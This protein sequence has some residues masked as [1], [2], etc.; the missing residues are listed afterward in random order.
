MKKGEYGYRTYYKRKTGILILLFLI[1]IAAQYIASR[2]SRTEGT[3]NILTVMAVLTVLPMANLAAPFLAVWKYRTP[4]RSQKDMVQGFADRGLL[5]FDL[6]ITFR[7]MILPLDYC[8]VHD[9]Q[10]LLYLS[11][12]GMDT[13]KAETLIEENLRL[14][15]LTCRIFI[16]EDFDLFLTHVKKCS[17][18]DE[19]GQ[20]A[21][22]VGSILKSLSV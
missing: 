12:K 8:L 10:A 6:I 5:L 14:N 21:K 13:K 3:R 19:T 1:A 4:D 20:G 18:T 17:P 7:E 11:Q 16:Y 22:S 15:R 2:M 9:N